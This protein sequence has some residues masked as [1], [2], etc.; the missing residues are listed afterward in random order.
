MEFRDMLPFLV[1]IL[2]A[3]GGLFM[4]EAGGGVYGLGMAVFALAVIGGFWA[5]KRYFDNIDK[6]RR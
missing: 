1:A 2:V 4:I 6:Q 5:I 3:I